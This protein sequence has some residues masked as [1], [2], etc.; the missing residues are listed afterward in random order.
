MTMKARII[1]N[2]AFS[3]A[4][5]SAVLFSC[6]STDIINPIP[7]AY[8]EIDINLN[9]TQYADL[10]VDNG[11][12]YILGGYKGIIIYRENKSTYKSFERASP[13]NPTDPCA[14]VDVDESGLFIVDP[15]SGA[16]FNFN[17]DPIS[18]PNG[19][20]LRAYFSILE[21]N[22]LYIRSE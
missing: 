22:W 12:V 9:D 8:V 4:I 18:S 15:C 5:L 7:Y 1:M 10:L 16:T 3:I 21:E 13:V 11:Y 14:I 6:S 20:P 19:V 2:R 17:G